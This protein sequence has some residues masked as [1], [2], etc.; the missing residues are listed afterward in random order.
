M[1]QIHPQAR[2]TPKTRVEIQQASGTLKPRSGSSP[3]LIAGEASIGKGL[4]G[5]GTLTNCVKQDARRWRCALG[6]A[7]SL[8]SRRW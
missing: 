6:L 2:T 7:K 1:S 8:L 5:F 4:A 3:P